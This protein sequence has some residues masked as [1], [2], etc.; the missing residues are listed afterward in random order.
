MG[1][2]H[3]QNTTNKVPRAQALLD[4]SLRSG[5]RLG[6]SR[7]ATEWTCQRVVVHPDDAHVLR[8]TDSTAASH[9]GRHLDFDREVG[10]GLQRQSQIASGDILNDLRVLEGGRVGAAR[11]GIDL[12]GQG[13]GTVLVHLAERESAFVVF[14]RRYTISMW[15]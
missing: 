14:R 7:R 5:R 1:V 2:S 6:E 13:A 11:G 10:R 8:A 9:P 12:G 15:M 4:R 3:A